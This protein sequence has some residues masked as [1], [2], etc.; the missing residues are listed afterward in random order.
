M[1]SN[2]VT[3]SAIIGSFRS[4]ANENK[5]S[6]RL[7][8]DLTERKFQV[9][10]RTRRDPVW[11]ILSRAKVGDILEVKGKRSHA[12]QSWEVVSIATQSGD[13]THV[14]LQ[15]CDDDSKRL[16]FSWKNYREIGIRSLAF[17]EENED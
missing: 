16:T 7:Y 4:W 14:V 10:D 2:K 5:K 9:S 8:D 15:G 12:A 6:R 11:A 13:C 17:S 1:T 3:L